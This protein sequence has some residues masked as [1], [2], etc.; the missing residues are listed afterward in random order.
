MSNISTLSNQYEKLVSTSDK[1]NNSVIAF[2]KKNL[3]NDRQNQLKYPKLKVSMEELSSARDTLLPFLEN[4]N[5]ILGE[6]HLESDFI[7]SLI[8]KDYRSKLS[9]EAFLQDDINRLITGL[10]NNQPISGH[11]ITILDTILSILDNERS[12]LFRKLRKARG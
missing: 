3:L 11:D 7:P 2:K 5:N 10:K 6:D 8:L 9:S 12:L 4:V 1:I